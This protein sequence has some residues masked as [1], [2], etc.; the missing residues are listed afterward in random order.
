MKV[1]QGTIKKLVVTIEPIG[2][3]TLSQCDFRAI[4]GTYGSPPPC[5]R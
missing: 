4:F 1:V 5:Y 2:N 3:M